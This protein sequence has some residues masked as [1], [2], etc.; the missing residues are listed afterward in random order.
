MNDPTPLL[1]ALSDPLR[2]RAYRFLQQTELTVTELST[3]LSV[4]QST[5]ST[6]L[7]ILKEADL[8]RMR[9][10]GRKVWYTA[11]ETAPWV[12]DATGPLDDT[13][14]EALVRTVTAR[15]LI[16]P[17]LQHT[18]GRS[19]EGLARML[20]TITRLGVIADIGIGSGELTTLLSK[21]STRLY[22]VDRSEAL[23]AALLLKKPTN[24]IAINQDAHQLSLPEPVDL[25]LLS[26]TLRQLERPE[27]ALTT[28]A[29]NLKP[30]ARL[31]VADLALHNQEL[32][33][34][35][36]GFEPE[37]LTQL[38]TL[39]GLTEITVSPLAQDSRGFLSLLATGVRP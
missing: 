11:T 7:K 13:D 24:I 3:L 6:L 18:P 2:L 12:T 5:T 20:L 38:F 36:P 35:W 34:R 4:G 23:L 39:A 15:N 10:E 27:L 21:S 32:G 16:D 26:N 22:A 17:A 28:C 31:I 29:H 37:R 14:K 8:A 33:D 9:P 1:R 25:L 30:G 19:W